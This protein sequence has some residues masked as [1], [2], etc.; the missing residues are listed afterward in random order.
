MAH[1]KAEMINATETADTIWD[2]QYTFSKNVI[3][4]VE[5]TLFCVPLKRLAIPG[6]FFETLF[7]LPQGQDSTTRNAQ[8]V[9]G[10]SEEN[11]IV[12]AGIPKDT[13]RDLLGILYPPSYGCPPLD[14][15]RWFKVMDLAIMWDLTEAR[16]MAIAALKD[17]IQKA[18]LY[19]QVARGFQHRVAIW[20]RPALRQMLRLPSDATIPHKEMIQ[21]GV[22]LENIVKIFALREIVLKDRV[23]FGNVMNIDAVLMSPC[24]AKNENDAGKHRSVPS[25]SS[26]VTRLYRQ[27]DEEFETEFSDME[28]WD[29]KNFC[30]L[31]CFKSFNSNKQN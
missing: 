8:A 9:E 6:S 13:F 16:V 2:D 3:L 27:L 11:P 26:R 19:E 15:E 14:P 1:T 28:P 21:M 17:Y 22:S 12:L 10:D 20:L 7:S 23:Q 4:K 31:E 29:E 24:K 25:F 5:D 18:P 30:S